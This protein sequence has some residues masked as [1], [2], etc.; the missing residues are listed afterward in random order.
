MVTAAPLLP[1]SS[2]ARAVLLSIVAVERET[3]IGKDTLRAW[4][5]RYGFPVPERD[6]AGVRSYPR[7]LVERLRLVRQALV[8]GERSGRLFALLF[9]EFD[10]LLDRVAQA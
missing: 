5:R 3:G 1:D 4:E 2:P 10:A 7:A 8:A 9:G 6:A